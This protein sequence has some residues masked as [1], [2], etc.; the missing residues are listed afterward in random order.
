M[1]GTLRTHIIIFADEGKGNRI[2]ESKEGRT[3]LRG[4]ERN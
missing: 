3:G 2:K 1:H 4:Q